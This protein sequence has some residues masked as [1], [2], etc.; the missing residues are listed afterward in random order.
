MGRLPFDLEIEDISALADIINEK[1]LEKLSLE[2]SETGWKLELR[3]RPPVPP[4]GG[5]FMSPPPLPAQTVQHAQPVQ[6]DQQDQ[7]AAAAAEGN[8][9]KSPIVGTYYERPAPDKP[10]FVSIGKMVKKGDIVMIVES[11]KLMNEIRSEFDGEVK[12][13]LVKNGDPVEYDQPV[14]IIG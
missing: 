13:I 9:V 3:A 5:G 4:P 1:H 14:M 8:V 2:D 12:E 10:P 6:Q 7:P 11:M